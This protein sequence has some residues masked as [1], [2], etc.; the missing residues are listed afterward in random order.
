MPYKS[1]Y[2]IYVCLHFL[3]TVP[4]G[5]YFDCALAWEEHIDDPN[6]LVMTFEDMNQEI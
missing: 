4:W 1:S 3:L 5:S 6:I 2:V